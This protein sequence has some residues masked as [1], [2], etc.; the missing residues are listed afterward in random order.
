MLQTLFYLFVLFLML[1]GVIV[2]WGFFGNLVRADDSVCPY[3]SRGECPEVLPPACE[4][5]KPECSK[6]FR[7]TDE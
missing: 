3:L 5:E 2:V 1:C 6:S 7:I 4:R